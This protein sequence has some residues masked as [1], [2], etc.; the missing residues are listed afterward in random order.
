[1][2]HVEQ[3]Q[4]YEW[5][6]KGDLAYNFLN[7]DGFFKQL[8]FGGRYADRTQHVKSTTYNWGSL[9]ENWT[10]AGGIYMDQV[11]GNNV[12]QYTF[13]NFF[14][15]DTAAP[16]PGFIIA[17]I[18]STAM[19]T[20]LR[21]PRRWRSGAHPAAPVDSA[22]GTRWRRPGNSVPAER[23]PGRRPEDDGCLCHASVWQP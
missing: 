15:G 8:K 16:P 11:G 18:R 1:M 21:S 4:G 14:R 13:H 20:R 22:R 23:N 12:E 3:D 19:P 7:E 10:N 5:A 6:A 9:S 17:A 2:D